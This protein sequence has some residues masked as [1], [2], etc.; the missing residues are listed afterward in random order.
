MALAR[1]FAGQTKT[2]DG[3]WYSQLEGKIV[4][5]I[6]GNVLKWDTGGEDKFEFDK[7]KKAIIVLHQGHLK[8]GATLIL[9]YLMKWDTGD[10]WTKLK[11]GI[12][13]RVS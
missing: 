8:L 10:V 7:N 13:V 9:P 6:K 4:G 3:K 5:T 2:L 1:Q 12:Y 11:S